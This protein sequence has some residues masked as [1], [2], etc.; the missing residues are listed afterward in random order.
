MLWQGA[1]NTDGYPRVSR[2]E[3]ATGER[4]ANVKLHRHLYEHMHGVTLRSVDVVRHTCDNPQCIRPEHL[5]SGS[6]T[7]NA[8]D[9]QERGRTSKIVTV[10]EKQLILSLSLSGEKGTVIAK[11]IGIDPRRVYYVLKKYKGD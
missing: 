7:D 10:K 6:A 11:A 9:R 3:A 8:R 1:L 2:L 5:V 4:S